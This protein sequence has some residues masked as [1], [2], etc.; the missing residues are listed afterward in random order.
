MTFQV[1]QF[2]RRFISREGGR[3]RLMEG[4]I[5]SIC[6]ERVSERNQECHRAELPLARA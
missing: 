3:A 6:K 5:L 4:V 1:R 2:S